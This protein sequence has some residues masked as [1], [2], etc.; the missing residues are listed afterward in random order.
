MASIKIEG[1]KSD[2]LQSL[3]PEELWLIGGFGRLGFEYEV[4]GRTDIT[5]WND[6]RVIKLYKLYCSSMGAVGFYG[7]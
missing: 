5:L 1:I 2:A 4:F 6:P 3:A 7:P